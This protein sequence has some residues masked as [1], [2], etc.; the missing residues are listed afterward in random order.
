MNLPYNIIKSSDLVVLKTLVKRCV[1]PNNT[2]QSVLIT[3][4]MPTAMPYIKLVNE[5]YPV[6]LVIAIPYS[7]D[8]ET[9]QSL[10]ASGISTFLPTS[11]E[12]AFLQAGP[13]VEDILK[14][15][16]TPLVVQEVGG[17]LA[18]Y[19]EQLSNY[20]H[21]KGIVEDTNNGQWRYE[22]AGQHKVPVVS[23]ALSPIKD[24]EDTVIGDSV[25][26]STERIFRE[27]FHAVIQGVRAGV[28]GYGKIGTSTSI[29][30]KGRESSVAIY[31]ID[32]CKC[33]QARFEG[34]RIS[35]LAQLLSESELIIGCTGKTSI[36]EEN[37]QH[38]RDHSILVSG[39]AKNEEFD[40]VAFEKYC[41][42]EEIS[43]IVWRYTQPDGR[44]FYLLNRGTPVNF[45][46]R[47]I[48]GYIL[49]MI[50]S[51][52]FLCMGFIA[53]DRASIGLQQSSSIIHNEVAK[54]WLKIYESGFSNDG[55]DNIWSFPE[56]LSRALT[57]T[58]HLQTSMCTDRI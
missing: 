35:P 20:P 31:D 14:K 8:K 6:A 34:L 12:E 23:M 43:P 32:P 39:S 10:E 13:L 1:K 52:L 26:Y 49:D 48:L 29:A 15:N 36:R 7:A 2:C 42:R 21:F 44:C 38:I 3:H 17:Y 9:L 46:D 55:T 4:V 54:T 56:S 30:L 53:N 28:I 57:Q 5:I 22:N 40:L 18:G 37:I 27:E 33:I 51:E 45:R 19:T 50:Y 16:S 41:V 11:V 47:S 24:I 25:V 58:F